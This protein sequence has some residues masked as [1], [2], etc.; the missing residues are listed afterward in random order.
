M[1]PRQSQVWTLLMDPRF[2]WV[3]TWIFC[4]LCDMFKIQYYIE[5]NN[6]YTTTLFYI[7]I[8]MQKYGAH[9]EEGYY[10]N[11]KVVAS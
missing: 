3:H 5:Y 8:G 11:Q 6:N 4:Y 10:C 1:K 2:N 9:I 7:T